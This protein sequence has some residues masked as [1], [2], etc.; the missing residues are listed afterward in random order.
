MG[1]SGAPLLANLILMMHEYRFMEKRENDNIYHVRQLNFTSRHI[2][3][4]VSVNNPTFHT[5]IS[6]IYPKEF[7]IKQENTTEDSASYLELWC[8][9]QE[10]QFHTT[11]LYDK[12]NSFNFNVVNYP[13]VKQSNMPETPVYGV[14]TSRLVCIS[15]VC[16]S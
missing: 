15:R 6:A 4:I 7:Q 14:N 8:T 11:S 9:I 3:D 5:F 16:D 13:F 12:C 2:E 10:E 1:I